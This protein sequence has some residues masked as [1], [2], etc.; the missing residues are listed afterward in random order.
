MNCK[1]ITFNSVDY[2]CESCKDGYYNLTD[3][4]NAS[5][6]TCYYGCSIAC[7]KCSGPHYGMCDAC[8]S[9]TE[10][11]L[12]NRHCIPRLN[13]NDG[14]AFQHLYTAFNNNSFFEANTS[15]RLIPPDSCWHEHV[16]GG[17]SSITIKLSRLGVYKLKL[18]WKV[19]KYDFSASSQF[20]TNESYTVTLTNTLT[21]NQTNTSFGYSMVPFACEERT[22]FS[23]LCSGGSLKQCVDKNEITFENI[24]T[25]A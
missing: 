17:G 1:N 16:K 12:T 7:S 19:Y 22:G 3:Y 23:A 9:D 10:F 18:R 25:A 8:V 21:T 15:P 24:V 5:G 4:T 13:L 2:S 6:L 20:P 14:T 11:T